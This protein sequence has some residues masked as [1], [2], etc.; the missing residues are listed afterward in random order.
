MPERPEKSFAEVIFI[1]AAARRLR[2]DLVMSPVVPG[3]EAR[4]IS[5][6]VGIE[7]PGRVILEPPVTAGGQKIFIPDGWSL[8][9]SFDLA[10]VWFQAPTKVL[11]HCMFHLSP[12]HRID[13]LAVDLPARLM[14]SNR[15]NSPRHE[16][17]PDRAAFA[18][19]WSSERIDDEHLA[20]LTSG[21]LA[22]WSSAGLGVRVS[23]PPDLATGQGA[24]ICIEAP[25]GESVFM[26]GMLCHCTSLGDGNWMVGFGEIAGLKPGEAI[27]LMS[28]LASPAGNCTS[29]RG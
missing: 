29:R 22:D 4:L 16:I 24:V 21:R 19:I 25:G 3:G 10:N 5:R 2:V 26:R 15:R 17:A 23:E 1:E 18:R 20:P 13:A 11:D 27:N 12:T 9:M 6:F 8:G 7:N 28:L 14:S